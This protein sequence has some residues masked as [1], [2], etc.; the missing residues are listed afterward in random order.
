[1]SSTE[2]DMNLENAYTA[3]FIIYLFIYLFIYSFIPQKNLS[4]I[5]M[6]KNKGGIYIATLLI[7][8]SH[9]SLNP[10]SRA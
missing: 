3:W 9:T 2:I 1:M 7:I 5:N 4:I 8:F 10:F 6:Q